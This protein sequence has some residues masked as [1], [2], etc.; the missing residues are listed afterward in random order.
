MTSFSELKAEKV[1]T[2]KDNKGKQ[3]LNYN[4]LQFSRVYPKGKNLE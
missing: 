3:F 4:M 1:C 2:K